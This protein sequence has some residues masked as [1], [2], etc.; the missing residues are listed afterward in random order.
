MNIKRSDIATNVNCKNLYSYDISSV[1][2]S[3]VNPFERG[4]PKKKKTTSFER[5]IK[6]ILILLLIFFF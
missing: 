4:G 3:K 6:A 1:D 2:F 5:Y